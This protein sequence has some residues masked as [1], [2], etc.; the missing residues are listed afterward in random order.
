MLYVMVGTF[1]RL[2]QIKLCILTVTTMAIVRC[3]AQ[4]DLMLVSVSC[5]I[6]SIS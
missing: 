4:H 5:N 2:V 6:L 3:T 1:E